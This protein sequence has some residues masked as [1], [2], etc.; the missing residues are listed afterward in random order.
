[1]TKTMTQRGR[2]QESQR[3]AHVLHLLLPKQRFLLV[4]LLWHLHLNN[5]L[6]RKLHLKRNQS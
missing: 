6:L 5:L 4:L 1:M 3:P 2:L